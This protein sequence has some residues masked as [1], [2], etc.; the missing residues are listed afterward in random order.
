MARKHRT[1]LSHVYQ[2]ERAPQTLESRVAAYD[3]YASADVPG[4][5]K[6]ALFL[7]VAIVVVAVFVAA[8]NNADAQS[9]QDL[10]GV[11]RTF[12]SA[13][14]NGGAVAALQVCAESPEGH[15]ALAA[16]R[17]RVFGALP[18]YDAFD[19]GAR[20]KKLQTLERLRSELADEG[21]QWGAI[22]PL[23]MSGVRARVLQPSLMKEPASLVWGHLYFSN[24][25]RLFEI[26]VTAWQCG[27]RFIIADIWDWAPLAVPPSELESFAK[28]RSRE[29]LQEQDDAPDDTKIIRPK[30]IFLAI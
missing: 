25:N 27:D 4:W 23:A 8:A 20:A 18:G 17:R 6:P 30:R 26:E 24:A 7:G 19:P 22:E 12:L 5:L 13:L 3:W 14:A 21:V 11:S 9:N 28:A 15:Q 1:S 29:F 2:E 16:E 10:A